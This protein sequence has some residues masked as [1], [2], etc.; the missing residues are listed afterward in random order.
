MRKQ[1]RPEN[2]VVKRASD[3]AENAGVLHLG[4]AMGRSRDRHQHSAIVDPDPA[5]THLQAAAELKRPQLYQSTEATRAESQGQ[6]RVRQR[7]V[8]AVSA[9]RT[10]FASI[11][12]VP[13]GPWSIAVWGETPTPFSRASPTIP[14]GPTIPAPPW[15]ATGL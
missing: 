15:A 10:A 1:V 4:N 9:D 11:R 7:Q 2:K 13:K 14:S 12:E 8:L 5:M 3:V 6:Q